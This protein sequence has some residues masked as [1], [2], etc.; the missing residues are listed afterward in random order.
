MDLLFHG[1][2]HR[3]SWKTL[4]L[5]VETCCSFP[6][7]RGPH[8]SLAEAA[9][10][11]LCY[12]GPLSQ[13]SGENRYARYLLKLRIGSGG[14]DACHLV[15]LREGDK[16]ERGDIM[17]WQRNKYGTAAVGNWPN[18]FLS[19]LTLVT[20]CLKLKFCQLLYRYAVKPRFKSIILL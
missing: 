14:R 2:V 15:M 19:L 10:G 17:Y 20:Q 18:V 3:R 5:N 8:L 9:A 1:N 16:Y 11:G 4:F 12:L 7:R 13:L 6:L